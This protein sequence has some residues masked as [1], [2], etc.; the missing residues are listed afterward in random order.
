MAKDKVTEILMEALKRALE[1]DQPLVKSGKLSG[2]F[3]SKSGA[4]GQALA[5]ALQDGLLEI[6]RTE[7][8]GKITV[9]WARITPAGVNF[10]HDHESPL[11]ALRDL[12]EALNS[13]QDGIP[14]W[15]AQ[16]QRELENLGTRLT[17]E[18]QLWTQRFEA[19]SQRITEALRRAETG[20]TLNSNGVMAL[21][22]WAREAFD[23]LDRRQEAFGS[24]GCPFPELFAALRQKHGEL[25]MTAFHSGLR[26]L[27]DGKAVR[28][29]PFAESGELP[30]PEYALLDGPEV[31]YYVSR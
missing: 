15:L 19:L 5:R 3:S 4:N 13:A 20:K 26:V 22:P 17:E 29:L 8:K 10:L 1:T 31:L 25:S 12:Q 28:L 16:M 30:Q 6:T 21:V 18:A 23:Y 2:L 11:R 9:D 14:P 27:S 24:R 7:N